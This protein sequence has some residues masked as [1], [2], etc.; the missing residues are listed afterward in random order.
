MTGGLT[1][2]EALKAWMET[3]NITGEHAEELL[4]YGEKLTEG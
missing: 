4:K 1:P 2:L 3:K